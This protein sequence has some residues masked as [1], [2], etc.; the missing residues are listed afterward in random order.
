MKENDYGFEV[1]A[2]GAFGS[3]RCRKCGLSWLEEFIPEICPECG[4]RLTNKPGKGFEDIIELMQ[5]AKLPYQTVHCKYCKLRVP[6][7]WQSSECPRCKR[8]LEGVSKHRKHT[9]SALKRFFKPVLR[10]CL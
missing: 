3:V 4:N 9:F 6:K 1:E 7:D 10:L 2:G 5:L 8:P